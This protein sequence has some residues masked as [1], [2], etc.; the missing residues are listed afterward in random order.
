MFLARPLKLHR[1][2]LHRAGTD[3]NYHLTA[4]DPPSLGLLLA[5]FSPS[6]LRHVCNFP[7]L[8]A[9]SPSSPLLQGESCPSVFFFHCQGPAPP[10]PT[11]SRL[12][13]P[14]IFDTRTSSS[15][16]VAQARHVTGTDTLR[17][18]QSLEVSSWGPANGSWYCTQVPTVY[19]IYLYFVPVAA[20]SISCWCGT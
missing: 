2:L 19:L 7:L 9:P 17:F 8:F 10:R 5:F 6:F 1:H 15:L 12:A 20:A 11:V 13:C 3:R 16:I 14:L 4:T 18:P